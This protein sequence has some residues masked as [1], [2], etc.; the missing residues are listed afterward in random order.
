MA[1]CQ[2][3]LLHNTAV[4]HPPPMVALASSLGP[5]SSVIDLKHH[6]MQIQVS[7]N[8]SWLPSS[9]NAGMLQTESLANTAL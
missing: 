6:S 7:N 8:A 4:A 2:A 5:P 9:V 1:A 3:L